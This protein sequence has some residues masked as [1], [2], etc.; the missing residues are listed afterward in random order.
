MKKILG[1]LLLVVIVGLVALG[2][3][4]TAER[5][6]VSDNTAYAMPDAHPPEGVTLSAL[7]AGKMFSPAAFAYRGGSFTEERVFGLGG[8]LVQ[9][10]QGT[11]LFDAGFGSKVDEHF[12]T[13]PKMMQATSKYAKEKTVAEQLKA[14]GIEPASLKGIV[15]THAHWDHIS[16]IEDLPGAPVW[17]TQ[18]EK[19]FIQS[20]DNKL[21]ALMKG[22][23][24]LPYHVYDFPQGAYL[25]YKRSFDVF[26]DGSV[27][28]VPVP[29]HTPGSIIAFIATT[30]GKRY[31]LV[32]D[33][34]WQTEGIAIPAQRPFLARDQVDWDAERVR[35][36]V[37]HLHALKKAMPNLIMVPAHDRRVW[38]TLPALKNH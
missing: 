31:A 17:V 19:D 38:E 16:G 32:G 24:A 5:L 3:S 2:S 18:A 20:T 25:G 21:F 4:F 35:G 26:G 9:H 13:I 7:M 28:L 10:P 36:V 14:N 12:R 1:L 27:V 8:I 6:P 23:G 29:G 33:A 37:T 15:I 30:D 11:L 22:F 34:V